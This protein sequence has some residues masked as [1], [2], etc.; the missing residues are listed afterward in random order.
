MKHLIVSMTIAAIF[1]SCDSDTIVI[2]DSA[3]QVVKAEAKVS[4]S[5]YGEFVVVNKGTNDTLKLRNSEVKYGMTAH[6]GNFISIKFVPDQEHADRKFTT[7]YTLHDSTVVEDKPEYEYC[8]TNT[9]PGNYNLMLFARP[10]DGTVI[11]TW[12]CNLALK[13]E[14]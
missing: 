4:G 2:D 6:N 12:S 14:D 3:E 7:I 13:V 8:I 10:T 5:P 11:S 1:A 9:K